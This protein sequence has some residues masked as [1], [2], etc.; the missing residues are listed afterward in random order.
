M[1]VPWKVFCKAYPKSLSTLHK[2]P[3]LAW[4]QHQGF[5]LLEVLLA[6]WRCRQLR[7]DGGA[8]AAWPFVAYW[9]IL[10]TPLQNSSQCLHPANAQFAL[11]RSRTPHLWVQICSKLLPSATWALSTRPGLR[12]VRGD[13]GQA[14]SPRDHPAHLM[15]AFPRA[16]A[17]G[18]PYKNCM[19]QAQRSQIRP[20][21]D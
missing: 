13:Q 20:P 1:A 12:S 17:Q 21:H 15:E 8:A 9:A 2:H 5:T 4:R 7:F 10:K 14:L 11:K 6:V 19:G 16:R 3:R 18:D